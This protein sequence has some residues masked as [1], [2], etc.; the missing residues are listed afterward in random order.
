MARVRFDYRLRP[1]VSATRNALRLLGILGYPS[2]IVEGAMRRV[3][4]PTRTT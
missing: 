1:G 2:D 3:S 4:A